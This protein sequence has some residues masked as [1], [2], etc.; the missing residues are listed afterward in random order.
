MQLAGRHSYC[1]RASTLVPI[2]MPI[3][4][5]VFLLQDAV[6][7][8][9]TAGSAMA[10]VDPPPALYIQLER[11]FP[12]AGRIYKRND[13]LCLADRIFRVPAFSA[14]GIDVDFIS[15]QVMAIIVHIGPTPAHGHYRS[16]LW[17]PRNQYHAQCHLRTIWLTSRR[18]PTSFVLPDSHTVR[19]LLSH[20]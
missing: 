6:E 10:L 17:H 4:G 7:E 15:Y 20:A 1:G 12:V 3:S 11:Y 19:S 5:Q 8:W 14:N 13:G 2:C 18:T 16:P 9:H